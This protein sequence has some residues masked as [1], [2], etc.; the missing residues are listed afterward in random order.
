M[1]EKQAHIAVLLAVY[2]G[3]EFIAEQVESILS[4]KG[5][6]THIFI[7][8]DLSSDDS[9]QWCN[10]FSHNRSHVTLLPYGQKFGGAAAN[11]Y[12]LIKEVD[13]SGFD[14]IA[15]SDQDDLWLDD[16]LLTASTKLQQEYFD[17]YSSNVMAFWQDGRQHLINKALPQRKYDYLFEAAGPG[18]TYVFRTPPLLL[19]KKLITSNWEQTQQVGLHD[20]L[21]YAFFRHQGLKWFIDP[22][23]KL[24]YR[25]HTDNQVGIN[26]GWRANLKR[27][28]LL[29]NGWCRQ[30]VITIAALIDN[31]DIDVNSRL[32]ILKNITQLR[33]RF[34]DRCLLFF[35]AL[36]G[37][38]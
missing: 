31:Q 26:K 3:L 23:Y 13:F 14:C 32:N 17:A 25:Q 19:F 22:N 18:C 2:N 5:V 6:S 15:L 8:V 24:L 4:Q 27:L 20:W 7:S 38:Y 10:N 36:L 30:Q 11:F 21:L 12:H 29:R 28:N 1:S 35:I 9:Y 37:F 34:R 16:K 33:R